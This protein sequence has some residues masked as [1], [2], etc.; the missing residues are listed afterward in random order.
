MKLTPIQR[1]LLSLIA[2]LHEQRG[3]RAVLVS[4]ADKA[5]TPRALRSL[6]TKEML[7]IGS[8]HAADVSL[9]E[10]RLTAAGRAAAGS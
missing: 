7:L 5:L 4:K 1:D 9:V 2:F 8:A 6:A 10:I 3:G